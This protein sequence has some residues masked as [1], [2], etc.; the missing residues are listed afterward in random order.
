[1]G[2][3]NEDYITYSYDRIKRIATTSLQLV[4]DNIVIYERKNYKNIYYYCCETAYNENKGRLVEV[5]QN[6]RRHTSV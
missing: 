2:C 5:L 6:D 3:A 1:M 4:Q